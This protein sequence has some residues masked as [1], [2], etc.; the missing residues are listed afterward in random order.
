MR[1]GTFSQRH[2]EYYDYDTGV[3]YTPMQHLEPAQA[4]FEVVDSSL[5]EYGVMGFE[6]GYSLGDP[7]TLTLWEGQ[8]GDFVNGAQI[9]IDQFISCCEAKWGQPSGVGAAAADGY[10]GQGPESQFGARGAFFCNSAPR[11]TCS[12]QRDHARAVFHLLRRQMYGG[13]DRARDAQA[14]GD[15]HAESLLCATSRQ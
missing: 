7:L 13:N 4:R 14:A 5:S 9:M 15:L 12:L 11:T 2:L 10:E 8:F 6:F 3:V 1:A